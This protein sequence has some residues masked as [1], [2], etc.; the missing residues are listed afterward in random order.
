LENF[1]EKRRHPRIEVEWPA[2]VSKGDDFIEGEVKNIAFDGISICCEEPLPL[3]EIISISI[4]PTD[5]RSIVISGRVIWS[6]V[7]GI[8]EQN[9]TYG[10]GLCFVKISDQD[11]SSYLELISD[12]L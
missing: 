5:Q 3:D 12:L 4:E 2:I 11:H 9:S 7:Y 8:D 10:I 1:D 6:D